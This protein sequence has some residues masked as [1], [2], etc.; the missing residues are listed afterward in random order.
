MTLYRYGMKHR[1]VSVGAQP[2]GFL[3]FEDMD[4][5]WCGYYSYVFYDRKLTPQELRDYEIE[6]LGEVKGE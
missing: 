6:Y 1:G 2:K 3:F 5:D 4:K